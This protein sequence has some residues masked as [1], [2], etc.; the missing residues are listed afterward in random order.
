MSNKKEAVNIGI[1]LSTQLITASLT[2]IILIGTFST[3]I[4]D[5]R[6]VG[7]F[8]YL[9]TFTAFI[10]FILSLF[11]GGKGINQARRN[12][13]NGRWQINDTKKYFN[14]QSSTALFGIII[15]IISIFV[16]FYSN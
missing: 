9:L 10:L 15:F 1:T 16:S 6:D 7:L 13:F 14:K 2:M 3:F 12:G 8:Y 11:Y 5:K 4:V